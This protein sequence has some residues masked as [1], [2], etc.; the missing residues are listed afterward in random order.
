[1]LLT[2]G[3][4][5]NTAKQPLLRWVYLSHPALLHKTKGSGGAAKELVHLTEEEQDSHNISNS[6]HSTQE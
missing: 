1:M 4:R 5:T 2:V 6:L 3:V